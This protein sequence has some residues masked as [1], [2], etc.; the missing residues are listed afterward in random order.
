MLQDAGLTYQQFRNWRDNLSSWLEHLPP[1]Q[2]RP[3]DGPSQIAY[4]LQEQKVRG[5]VAGGLR[6]DRPLPRA[7][8]R[9]TST[10]TSHWRAA[11]GRGLKA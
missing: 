2:V 11:W 6:Q 9:A 4:K 5:G 7:G 1:S 3:G 8:P 10:S